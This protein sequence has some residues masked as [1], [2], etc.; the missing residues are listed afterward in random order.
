[1]QIRIRQRV[2]QRQELAEEAGLASV[3]RV[4]STTAIHEVAAFARAGQRRRKLPVARLLWLVVAMSLYTQE[5]VEVVFLRLM[6]GLR[7]LDPTAASGLISKSALCQGRAR[8][9]VRPVAALFH[10][11]CRPL[12]TAQT[13]GAFLFGLRMVAMDGTTDVVADT[14]ANVRAFGRTHG[15]RGEAA[16]PHVLGIYLVEVGTHAIIDAGFWPSTTSEHRGGARLL[17]SVT[18][19]MLLL[20]DNG[21]HSYELTT[22]VQAQGAHFLGSLPASVRIRHATPLPD[23]STWCWLCPTDPVRRRAGEHLL[24][25]VISYRLTDPARPHCG[26]IR[27]LVTSLLDPQQYPAADLI[28]AYHERWEVEGTIDELASHQRLGQRPLRSQTP[29]GVLQELY[30]VLLVHYALRALML[31][32]AVTRGVDPDRISFTR[33]V[34]LVAAALPLFQL[35]TPAQQRRLA[36]RLLHA[37]ACHLLP[38]RADRSEPRVVKR[39]QARFPKKRPQHRGIPPLTLPFRDAFVIL[40]HPASAPVLPHLDLAVALI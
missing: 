1:M 37:L 11:V 5:A 18:A 38:P 24:V 39:V 40:P 20:Y 36:A 7:D 15:Y 14:P 34:H 32:A 23:G 10:Q 12:A 28:G 6:A 35:A 8:L 16:Y 3:L 2:Q 26:T 17:R 13:P 27:R 9:G 31:Q 19:E 22:R 29:T 21:Y 33:T 25:R 30:G 4:I